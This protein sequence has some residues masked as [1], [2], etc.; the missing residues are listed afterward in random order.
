MFDIGLVELFLVGALA[1]VLI[2]PK[3]LPDFLRNMGRL[4]ARVRRLYRDSL[5]SFEQLQREINIASQPVQQADA[6]PDYYA[7]L[8]EHVK[9]AMIMTEPV[10]DSDV[11]ETN[12]IMIETAIS[13]ARKILSEQSSGKK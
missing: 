10:R 13:D 7:L 9:Q 3:E 8:P 12:E 5:E 2:G 1:L 4:F 6:E 11:R